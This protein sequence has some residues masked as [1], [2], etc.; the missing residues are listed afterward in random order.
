MMRRHPAHKRPRRGVAHVEGE[1]PPDLLEELGLRSLSPL[2]PLLFTT[3]TL[4]SG[5]THLAREAGI[6]ARSGIQL[7][8]F[9][10]DRGIG[11]LPGAPVPILI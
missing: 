5:A 6:V 2:L 3:G 1:R 10:A 9:L 7:A 11:M 4:T 8:V